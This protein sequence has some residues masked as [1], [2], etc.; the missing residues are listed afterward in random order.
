MFTAYATQK[1]RKTTAAPVRGVTGKGKGFDRNGC[2]AQ[3]K[4]GSL[5]VVKPMCRS[6][7]ENASSDHR[8]GKSYTAEAAIRSFRSES[9]KIFV[10]D[11]GKGWKGSVEGRPFKEFLL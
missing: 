7:T 5:P 6:M 1:Q 3:Q 9:N 8:P 4:L 11:T 10:I 2:L